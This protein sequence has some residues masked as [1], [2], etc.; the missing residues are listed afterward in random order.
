VT[1]DELL[2]SA[3]DLEARLLKEGDPFSGD[4]WALMQIVRDYIRLRTQPTR[5]TC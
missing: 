1:D 2:T 5:V 3:R 4:D